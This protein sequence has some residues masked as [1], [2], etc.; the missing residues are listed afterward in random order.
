VT[1]NVP[2]R[3]AAALTVA[4]GLFMAVLDSTIVNVA[5]S[6]METDFHTDIN[7]IQW[8]VTGYTLVQAAVIPAAGYLSNR[9]GIKRLFMASLAIF[10]VGSLLCGLSPDLGGAKGDTMLIGFRLLQGIGGGMLFPLGTAIAF[11]VFPPEERAISSAVIAVPVLMAP[12]FGP[13][14]GGLIVDSH[15]GWPG[16]FFINVP[17]GIVTLFLLWRVLK[18][19]RIVR[20]PGEKAPGFDIP[21]LALSMAGVVLAVYAF[22]LVSQTKP[23]SITPANPNGTVYGWGY[24]PV[25]V[26]FGVGIGLLAV[27]S[28]WE[29]KF[30]KDPVLDLRLYGTYDFSIASLVTWIT[31]AA[32]FGAFLIVPLFLQ[33]FQGHS[34]VAAG[35]ILMGQGI[36]AILGIQ[37]GTRFYDRIGPRA[38]VVGGMIVLTVS[39]WLL[40]DVK[41]HSTWRFFVPVLFL[42]GIGFGWTN[43]PV[44]TVAL[45]SITGNALP[46]ASSLFNATAQ[47]FTSIG[48]AVVSTLLVQH[49]A[50]HAS[51]IARSAIASGACARA[52]VIAGRCP[53]D[54]ILRSGAAGTSDVFRL[55]TFATAFA[56]II[57]FFLPRKS[58]KQQMAAAGIKEPIAAGEHPPIAME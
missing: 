36:G 55:L 40:S 5:L 51:D 9:L 29:L 32:V 44:Q 38:V 58:L 4:L 7:S 3:Y 14:I 26:L 23:G 50:S 35:L 6:T 15:F 20:A 21:G 56:V 2:Y 12:A 28:V 39:T 46:K 57:C 41:A 53:A 49:A 18:P 52:D 8:V 16:I 25:W 24:W 13:T 1:R 31:R 43:L 10:T 17:I 54:L 11:S 30:S 19:D 47:V 22:V 33:Q 27:F 34:A 48:V 42:R 45:Q 37:S